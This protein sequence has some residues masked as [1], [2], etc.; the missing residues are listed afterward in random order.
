[1]GVEMVTYYA[2]ATLPMALLVFAGSY[3]G[4]WKKNKVKLPLSEVIALFAFLWVLSALLIIGFSF[5]LAGQDELTRSTIGN[6]WGPLVVGVLVG[7]SVADWRRRINA[8][9]SKVARME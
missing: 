9:K 3:F 7:R 2:G 6:L 4:I 5:I 8:Q 1:M